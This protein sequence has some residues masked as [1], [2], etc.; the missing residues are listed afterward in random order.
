MSTLG[1]RLG[2]EPPAT[3]PRLLAAGVLAGLAATAGAVW[4]YSRRSS[5][6]QVVQRDWR[7]VGTLSE[8]WIHP[9]KSCRGHRV[10]SAQCTPD[11]LLSNGVYD[12]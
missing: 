2:L 6:G 4:L 7:P 5:I 9:V 3:E 11:G 1:E 12:R 10:Q 8:I